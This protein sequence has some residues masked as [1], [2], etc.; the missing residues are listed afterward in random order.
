M[1]TG[2]HGATVTRGRSL[3]MSR[4]HVVL[5]TFSWQCYQHCLIHFFIPGDQ[6]LVKLVKIT[7]QVLQ[8]LL[9]KIFKSSGKQVRP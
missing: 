7:E 9:A 6:K 5:F 3:M 4:M 8:V 1:E 2:I